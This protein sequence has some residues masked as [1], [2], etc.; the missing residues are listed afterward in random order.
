MGML[1]KGEL[2]LKKQSN[3]LKGE[4]GYSYRL[5]EVTSISIRSAVLKLGVTTLL[6]VAEFRKRVAKL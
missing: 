6:R 1:M 4:S 3:P 2:Y 5:V